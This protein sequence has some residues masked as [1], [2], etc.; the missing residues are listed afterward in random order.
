MPDLDLTTTGQRGLFAG[1]DGGGTKTHAVITDADGRVLGEGSG[2]AANPLR[3]GIETSVSNIFSAIENACDAASRKLSEIVAIECGIAGVR[4]QDFRSILRERISELTRVRTVEVVTDAEI[5][6]YGATLGE[7]GLVIIAGTGSVCI[8][9]DS[10]GKVAVAGG[11]G[12][13]AGDEGGGSGIGRRALQAIAKASDG[14]GRPTALSDLAVQY[15]RAGKLENL[16]V[17]IYAPGVDNARI[18]GFAKHVV[19]VATGGDVVAREILDEAGRELGAAAVAV[20]R[21]L[22]LE[23]DSFP[24]GHVGSVFNAGPLITD[25]IFKV[26]HPVA[27]R[28]HL[29]EPKTSPARAAALLAARAF[30]GL[31]EK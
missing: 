26:I 7:K 3:V 12:P 21:K 15:F 18:A 27:S 20:I 2:G 8:G 13:L 1:V 24:I 29:V 14:R 28:A 10:D 19:A 5:A 23:D 16:S 17:S 31:T 6:L 22:K 25:S 30:A 4:R 9:Q 11:W